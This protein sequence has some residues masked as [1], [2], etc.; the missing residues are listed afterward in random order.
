[1]LKYKGNPY[2]P[3]YS[4]IAR[5]RRENLAFCCILFPWKYLR[6]LSK[7]RNPEYFAVIVGQLIY[8]LI[9]RI[10]NLQWF[11]LWYSNVI[12]KLHSGILRSIIQTSSLFGF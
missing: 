7:I 4:L 8:I 9:S 5:R 6:K 11:I 10:L 1:M 3:K 12:Y 2:Y